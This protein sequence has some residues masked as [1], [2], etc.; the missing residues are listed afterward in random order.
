MILNLKLKQQKREQKVIEDEKRTQRI[1]NRQYLYGKY[2]EN[3][4]NYLKR[5]EEWTGDPDSCPRFRW[6]RVKDGKMSDIQLLQL[7]INNMRDM[8]HGFSVE[9][10]KQCKEYEIWEMQFK[11][12]KNEV[13]VSN[14]NV[15]LYEQKIE[16][17]SDVIDERNNLRERD[18]VP[19][20]SSVVVIRNSEMDCQVGELNNLREGDTV[21]RTSPVLEIKKRE[22]DCRASELNVRKLEKKIIIKQKRREIIKLGGI[23]QRKQLGKLINDQSTVSAWQGKENT[24]I[25]NKKRKRKK[26]GRPTV[27]GLRV[28]PDRITIN[29]QNV[30]IGTS[31]TDNEKTGNEQYSGMPN[32]DEGGTGGGLEEEKE[33][34]KEPS[35]ITSMSST[36]STTLDS[37]QRLFTNER[38][39]QAAWVRTIPAGS[40]SGIINDIEEQMDM[41]PEARQSFMQKKEVDI[42]RLQQSLD[43]W[44]TKFMEQINIVLPTEPDARVALRAVDLQLQAFAT[45]IKS[46]HYKDDPKEALTHMATMMTGMALVLSDTIA[47]QNLITTSLKSWVTTM[48]KWSQILKERVNANLLSG[49]EEEDGQPE[50][51]IA[52]PEEMRESNLSEEDSKHFDRFNLSVGRDDRQNDP[53]CL[54]RIIEEFT[55]KGLDPETVAYIKDEEFRKE[56]QKDRQCWCIDQ[57]LVLRRAALSGNVSGYYTALEMYHTVE[58]AVLLGKGG[59]PMGP[60]KKSHKQLI[61]AEEWKLVKS[62]VT[63]V[64]FNDEK[65]KRKLCLSVLIMLFGRPQ[66]EHGINIS[67]NQLAERLEVIYC[68]IEAYTSGWQKSDLEHKFDSKWSGDNRLGILI[69]DMIVNSWD[70]FT[71]WFNVISEVDMDT[72]QTTIQQAKELLKIWC[73]T[74]ENWDDTKARVRPNKW[75]FLGHLPEAL[76]RKV[77]MLVRGASGQQRTSQSSSV[78]T[79]E[80]RDTRSRSIDTRRSYGEARSRDRSRSQRREYDSPD[81]YHSRTQW[82]TPER[83]MQY[84][85]PVDRGNFRGGYRNDRGFRGGYGSGQPR[86]PPPYPQ[87]PP[88]PRFQGTRGRYMGQSRQSYGPTTRGGYIPGPDTGGPTD[89]GQPYVHR[90]RGYEGTKDDN[91]G[92]RQSNIYNKNVTGFQVHDEQWM[93]TSPHENKTSENINVHVSDELRTEATTSYAEITGNV[94]G[95]RNSGTSTPGTSRRETAESPGLRPYRNYVTLKQLNVVPNK[96]KSPL[97][98]YINSADRDLGVQVLR[99]DD[100]KYNTEK[101]RR[102]GHGIPHPDA[103]TECI[104]APRVFRVTTWKGS[105]LRLEPYRPDPPDDF[106]E[107]RI[108]E[109]FSFRYEGLDKY[110]A[111][112]YRRQIELPIIKIGYMGDSTMI[113]LRVWLKS[114]EKSHRKTY[115]AL[116]FAEEEAHHLR[117]GAA[118]HE[119]TDKRLDE[120]FKRSDVVVIK[121]QVDFMEAWYRMSGHENEREAI[122]SVVADIKYLIDALREMNSTVSIVVLGMNPVNA[123]F[124]EKKLPTVATVDSTAVEFAARAD[125]IL[126]DMIR[127]E[128]DCCFMSVVNILKEWGVC[129]K[130]FM[131]GPHMGAV[132]NMVVSRE[133]YVRLHEIVTYRILN[134]MEIRIPS[135]RLNDRGRPLSHSQKKY[136][137]LFNSLN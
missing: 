123:K 13:E 66:V 24:L 131:K 135:F 122:E 2:V 117:G 55:L 47:K 74:W 99:C 33:S 68:G 104:V 15:N 59:V 6:N 18:T 130:P 17:E 67:K 44:L 14:P 58:C 4:G 76:K 90:G 78:S 9:W 8:C 10:K 134:D 7:K 98:T 125:G 1:K 127:G 25:L 12:G 92:A 53:L 124:P 109:N 84:R 103:K 40:V 3:P 43:G 112:L 88:P 51:N 26:V 30:I 31:G 132:P 60:Y 46:D 5:V 110:F 87:P 100:W 116:R 133:I 36:T 21:P 27:N 22:M 62:L 23:D 65:L 106:Q 63:R 89:R 126:D 80:T 129:E 49:Q 93:D 16:K 121:T 120:Q 11:K 81:S 38:A 102:A 107:V 118:L 19:R 95:H 34:T 108:P 101:F 29:I 115:G 111:I 57:A 61:E 35:E 94:R 71:E 119:L 69:R 82:E 48:E 75:E 113:S 96:N 128:Y 91:I 56:I 136:L 105:R 42:E 32:P 86:F 79:S 77:S 41:E 114:W 52:V 28:K 54:S 73:I 45:K 50:E 70:A 97:V 20:T 39:L 37:P 64:I 85:A 137:E 72:L 83:Q